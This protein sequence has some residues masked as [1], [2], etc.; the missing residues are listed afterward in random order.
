MI[1]KAQEHQVELY[2]RSRKLYSQLYHEVKDHFISQ[3]SHLM[4][5]KSISFQEA[6]LETKISWKN[7]L[8]MVRADMFSFKKITRIEKVVLQQQFRKMNII[9]VLFSAGTFV[10][11]MVQ[12]ELFTILQ[13][14]LLLSWM[15]LLANSFITGK[16]KFSNYMMLSFHPLL[17]RNILMA[18]AVILIV[19]ALKYDYHEI[20]DLQISKLFLVYCVTVQLQLMYFNSKKI[21]VLI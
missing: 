9:S 4:N 18:A 20:A 3:I 5:E 12:S 2:L 16:M 14:L 17:V 8:E 7:E 1:T 10:L 15:V 21:N 19:G 11:L 6:F 13:I